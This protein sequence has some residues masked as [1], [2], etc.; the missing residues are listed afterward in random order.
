MSYLT[1]MA[2]LAVQNFLS[3][4]TGIVVAVALIR[5]LARHSAKAIGN[6]WV[7]LTRCDALHP[8]ALRRCSLLLR[9]SP[10]ASM[11]NFSAYKDVTMLE[12]VDLPAAE[13]RRRRQS[14]QGRRRQPRHGDPDDADADPAH[15]S[16]RL[17][18]GIK[19]LGTNGGG[20]LNANSAHPYENPTAALEFPG[21]AGHP[22]HPG[23]ADLHLRAHG[24]RH[25]PGLG[26][27]RRDGDPVHGAARD[28]RAQRAARQ[29][30]RSPRSASI[31]PRAP[32]SRAATWKAR[33][34]A[35]ASPPRRCSPRSP[36]APRAAP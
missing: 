28:C 31:R 35:S 33:R 1:Q 29:S 8:A 9:S 22:P 25:A 19:E 4:A 11:Q 15:G 10:R 13:D 27:A 20:F 6:F 7:D 24:G 16:H 14:A 21:D 17:A 30:A 32:C 3:A 34:R 23:G 5:G 18:G 26:G 36:P 2:G 12:T